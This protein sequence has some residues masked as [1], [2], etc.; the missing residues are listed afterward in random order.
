MAVS[1]VEVIVPGLLAEGPLH[2]YQGI[3]WW[4]LEDLNL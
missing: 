1:K 2:G 4:A 3:H